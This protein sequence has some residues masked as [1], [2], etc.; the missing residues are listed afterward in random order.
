MN[1]SPA[2][3]NDLAVSVVMPVNNEADNL[4]PLMAEIEAAMTTG[5]GFEV[6]VVDDGSTDSTAEILVQM[7][8]SR[9][10]LRRIAHDEA[11]GKA[12]AL[13]SG[14][15]GARAKYVVILDGDGQNDPAYI[16][17]M[18]AELENGGDRVGLVNSV[19]IG[20]K[21]TKFKRIQSCIANRIR[22]AILKDVTRDSVSGMKAFPRDVFLALPFFDGLHRFMPALVR[23]EGL[24]LRQVDVI[25]RPRQHGSTHYGLWNRLWVG[26]MDLAG[27]WWLIR[28][29]KRVARATEVSPDR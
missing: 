27:V 5:R 29:E 16:P 22:V 14:V 19:R 21:D 23:R 20:R 1:G 8:Q 25:D 13:R 28:R 12:A 3:A 17:A 4:A 26:I 18:L 10:W 7:M 11:C 9:P 2:D 15:R 24:E 6:V